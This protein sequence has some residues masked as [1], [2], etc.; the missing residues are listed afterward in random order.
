MKT[1]RADDAMRYFTCELR[2]SFTALSA[3][4][5]VI[6]ARLVTGF[7]EATERNRPLDAERNFVWPRAGPAFGALAMCCR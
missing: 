6:V 3:W 7:N 4:A 2:Y 1:S 5:L